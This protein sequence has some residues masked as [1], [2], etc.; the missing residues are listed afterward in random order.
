MCVC[1]CVCV[2]ETYLF[3]IWIIPYKSNFGLSL[4]EV[5]VPGVFLIKNLEQITWPMEAN[6]LEI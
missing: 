2:C 5:Q 3:F 6:A 4:Y 1:V